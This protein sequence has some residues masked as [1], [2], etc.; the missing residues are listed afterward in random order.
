MKTELLNKAIDGEPVC[1]CVRI[2]IT[3]DIAFF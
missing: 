3:K 2:L 1:V